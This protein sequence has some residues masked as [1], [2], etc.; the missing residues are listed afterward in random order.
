MTNQQ[1]PQ[2]PQ[3]FPQYQYQQPQPQPQPQ[4]YAQQPQPQPQEYTQQP[5]TSPAQPSFFQVP[6]S[7][8]FNRQQIIAKVIAGLGIAVFIVSLL[9]FLAT[10]GDF[11]PDDIIYFMISGISL[12]IVVLACIWNALATIG[13]HIVKTE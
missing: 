7:V 6:T 13:K 4:E 9:E 2:Q 1:P 12:V 8:S 5:P 3:D 10:R 11:G